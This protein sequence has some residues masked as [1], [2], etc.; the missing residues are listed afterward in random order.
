[1][2]LWPMC[3]TGKTKDKYFSNGPRLGH[4]WLAVVR[5]PGSLLVNTGVP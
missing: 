3:N 4:S 1:M 5:Q 2:L